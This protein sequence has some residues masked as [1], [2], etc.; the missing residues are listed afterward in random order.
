MGSDFGISHYE[1]NQHYRWPMDDD[2]IVLHCVS[3]FLWVL[4]PIYKQ[5]VQLPTIFTSS[6]FILHI[7]AL[8]GSQMR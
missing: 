3:D 4:S 1:L 8:L 5:L 6:Y 7:F 2:H